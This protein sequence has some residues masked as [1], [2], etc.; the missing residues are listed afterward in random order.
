MDLLA[1]VKKAAEQAFKV[2][3]SLTVE[4]SFVH[5]KSSSYNAATGEVELETDPKKIKVLRSNYSK[6][7]TVWESFDRANKGE[8]KFVALASTVDNPNLVDSI[9]VGD[10][11]Y[12][13]VKFTTDPASALYEFH[14]KAK[15]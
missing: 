13:V 1:Q 12:E 7:E 8:F 11:E 2:V 9:L 14:V 15:V 10:V 4:A 5:V 3:D 6:S